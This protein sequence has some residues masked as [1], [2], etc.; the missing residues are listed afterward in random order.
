MN[1]KMLLFV[2]ATISGFLLSTSG[3]YFMVDDFFN[4]KGF[5]FEGV[6]LFSIGILTLLMML[7]ASSIGKAIM[8]FSDVY[9]KQLDMQKDMSEFYVKTLKGTSINDVIGPLTGQSPNSMI[10]TNLNTGETTS[11]PL[12]DPESIKKIS[13]MIFGTFGQATQS[14]K[15]SL[16]NMNIAQLEKELSKALN[17][18]DFEKASQ[19]R[20]LIKKQK[21]QDTDPK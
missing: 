18:D 2:L 1:P 17:K 7:V 15:N 4:P 19:I 12:S 3:I 20:D 6:V 13:D 9:S 8:I 21:D 16:E 10:I 14:G 11:T 5:L